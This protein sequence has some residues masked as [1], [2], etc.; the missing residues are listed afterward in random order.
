MVKR[1]D[2]TPAQVIPTGRAGV[3]VFRRADVLAYKRR[4]GQKAATGTK[5]A[6]PLGDERRGVR[7]GRGR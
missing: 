2:L 1:G 4:R 3:F 5:N 7:D 6:A